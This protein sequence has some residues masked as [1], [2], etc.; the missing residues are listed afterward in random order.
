[1]LCQ[2]YIYNAASGRNGERSQIT[3][4]I[5]IFYH[6]QLIGSAPPH[7]L[8]LDAL[9][10]FSR[11]PYAFHIP[12]ESMPAGTYTLNVTVTD[13]ITSG[14]ATQNMNFVIE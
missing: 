2:T 11:I 9:Q 3:V 6:N 5:R 13:R 4:Q 1:M 12:L 10:D 8:L 14:S 7:S